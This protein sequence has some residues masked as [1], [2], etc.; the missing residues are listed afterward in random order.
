MKNECLLRTMIVMCIVYIDSR[1]SRLIQ[2][3]TVSHS[4]SLAVQVVAVA[5]HSSGYGWGRGT[6]KT[7]YR[8]VFSLSLPTVFETQMWK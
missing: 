1:L 6:Y 4:S 8:E 5:R 2:S 7:N 3:F